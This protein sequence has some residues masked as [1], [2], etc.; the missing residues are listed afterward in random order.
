MNLRRALVMGN[1]RLFSALRSPDAATVVDLPVRHLGFAELAAHKH[2]LVVSYRR[3][4]RPI[5]QPVWPGYDGDRVYIWTEAQAF[6]AK[7]LRR[8]PDALIAPCSFRGKPLANPIAAT[9]R[10]LDDPD[11]RRHAAALIQAQWGWKR[12]AFAATARPLTD[13]IYIELTPRGPA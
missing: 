9:A 13:V 3:D 5:A 7:R 12:K 10:I 1:K 8:N 4:G 2:S 6:K 11:E